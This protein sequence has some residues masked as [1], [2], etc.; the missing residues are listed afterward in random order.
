MLGSFQRCDD[1]IF[2]TIQAR[3]DGLNSWNERVL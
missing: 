1:R 3:D 2:F